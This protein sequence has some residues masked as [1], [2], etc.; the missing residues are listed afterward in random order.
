MN[1]YAIQQS[2][3]IGFRSVLSF[4]LYYALLFQ[5]R[6]GGKLKETKLGFDPKT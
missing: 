1:L 2:A 5:Q 6:D 3:F 4:L